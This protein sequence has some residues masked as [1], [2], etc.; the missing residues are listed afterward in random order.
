MLCKSQLHPKLI[1]T[2]SIVPEGSLRRLYVRGT[3]RGKPLQHILADSQREENLLG[4]GQQWQGE[5]D[6]DPNYQGTPRKPLGLRADCDDS[7]PVGWAD[8][9]SAATASR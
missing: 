9:L 3:Y 1:M 6:A 7:S 5:A 2:F 4:T 8:A